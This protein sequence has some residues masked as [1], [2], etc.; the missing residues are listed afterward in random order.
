MC[1]NPLILEMNFWWFLLRYYISKCMTTHFVI[2]SRSKSLHTACFELPF[3][4]ATVLFFLICRVWIY[5]GNNIFL[6]FYVLWSLYHFCELLWKCILLQQ[7]QSYWMWCQWI[8]PTKVL[9]LSFPWWR[10]QMETFS[11]FLAPCEWNPPMTGGFPSHRPVTHSYDV[12]FGVT[13]GWANNQDAGDLRC[14]RSHYD[15]T[16]VWYA[17]LSTLSL[18][19]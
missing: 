2:F 19:K 15:A 11:A 9:L 7:W 12:L 10:H 16:V 4:I 13:S 14:H 1:F 17:L 3:F 5:P 6:S 18:N 8:K